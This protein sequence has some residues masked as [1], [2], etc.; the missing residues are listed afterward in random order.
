MSGP[1][2][3]PTEE[4]NATEPAF[5]CNGPNAPAYGLTKR[6]EFAKAAMQGICASELFMDSTPAALAK[7]AVL[8]ADALLQELA[9]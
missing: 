4:Q 1:Q 9:K 5:P 7:E 2:G 6:E 8:L 3:N